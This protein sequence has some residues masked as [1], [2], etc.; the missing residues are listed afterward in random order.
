MAGTVED[1]AAAA[2]YYAE[3]LHTKDPS[4]AE[5]LTMICLT[6]ESAVAFAEEV[7]L[8]PAV[9]RSNNPSVR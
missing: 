7:R 4:A 2:R 8:L 5:L 1:A 6:E 3:T 9:N